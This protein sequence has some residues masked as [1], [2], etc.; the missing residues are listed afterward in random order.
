VN[1]DAL[2]DL[3]RRAG[4]AT[5]WDDFAGRPHVVAP[6]VLRPMLAALGLPA[7]TRGD[8]AASRR[9][10]SRRTSIHDIAPLVTATSGRPTRL[11]IGGNDPQPAK[12]ELEQGGGRD[13]CL[14]PARGRLR[15][16]AI[17]ETGYH[18]LLIDDREIVL[19]VAPPRCREIDDVVPDARL[20]GV[21]AQVY[22]LKSPGDCGVGDTAGVAA[23]AESVAGHGA[24]ALALSPLHALFS[25]DPARFSPYAP[26]SRLF[27]N[28]LHADARWL[29]TPEM[30]ER[31]AQEASGNENIAF[32]E[33]QTLIDWP[34]AAA[35]KYRFFRSLFNAFIDGPEMDSGL[36]S[37]F[38][39]FWNERGALLTQHAR[40]EAL[41]A[42]MMPRRDW[43][44]W[45]LDLRDPCGAAVAAFSQARRREVA[46]H[47]FLQWIAD[48]SLRRAQRAA[49]AAGMRIGLIGD[50]AV[51]MDPAG[52][53]AWSRQS[54]ILLGLTIGAPPDLLNPLGQSWG[55]TSFSP[56]AL[57]DHGFA[58]FI[59]TLRAAMR[60][61][62]GIRVDHA[63]SL[64]RLWLVPEGAS[65]DQG[66][67]LTYPLA[68]LLRLLALESVRHGAVVIGEDL[69]TL[70]AGFSE[71][72][73]Q[74]G[75]HGMRVLWFERDTAAFS[76]P[77]HWQ[78]SAVAMTSTHDL[79][80]LAGWWH[81]EDLR[82]RHEHNRLG[83]DADFS[84]LKSERGQD[85]TLLWRR[86]VEQ[87][88][89]EG[90]A[91]DRANAAPVVD[92]AI[93]LVAQTDS[94]LCLVPLEDL[95]AEENQPNLPGTVDEYPNWRRR[96]AVNAGDV[97]DAPEPQRRAQAIAS[98]RPRR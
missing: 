56:R 48:R 15:V 2:K 79:P 36:G 12:L 10:V 24:D 39:G 77:S 95:L 59:D 63:M 42:S 7:E 35:V 47:V 87:H 92:G 9:A 64:A 86:L 1:D 33:Q 51:G 28:P 83:A 89:A 38:N 66:A 68:D 16:P 91:P 82:A 71:T 32:L 13:I 46:F 11:E 76:E 60:N 75:V 30:V 88:T 31:A 49:L 6:D 8:L 37:D 53:H 78:R 25:A 96:L 93:K 54:D 73:E 41:H 19:A 26:S 45:P 61:A 58:P 74:A 94:V 29:F 81:G 3:A 70:P 4:I 85:R 27:L 55:L 20:W 5:E 17:A 80:T 57:V 52:S 84:Q 18:R 14:V 98:A 50:M 40:F 65:P 97:L 43:R 22:G 90:E 69:G 44:T 62:G 67:Y 72:L 34:N 23:L 21:A